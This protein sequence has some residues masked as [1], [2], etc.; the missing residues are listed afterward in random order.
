MPIMKN[1]YKFKTV[2]NIVIMSIMESSNIF[3]LQTLLIYLFSMLSFVSKLLYS[4]INGYY[5]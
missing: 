5:S 3:V 1:I 2:I 4:Y